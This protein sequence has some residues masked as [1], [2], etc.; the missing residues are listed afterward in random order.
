MKTASI[1]A[2]CVVLLSLASG[3]THIAPGSAEEVHSRTTFMGVV[4]E[5]D[6][7][8][9][10]VTNKTVRAEEAKFKL[11]FP[12]FDRQ[13]TVKGLILQNPPADKP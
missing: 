5:Q 1:F 7:T 6:L 12:G 13:T 4:A 3:C 8:G 2:L 11:S 9:I 10:K